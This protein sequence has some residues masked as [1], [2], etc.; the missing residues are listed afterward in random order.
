MQLESFNE[1]HIARPLYMPTSNYLL[2]RDEIYNMVL[3]RGRNIHYQLESPVICRQSIYTRAAALVQSGWSRLENELTQEELMSL[4]P[5]FNA[6]GLRSN[7]GDTAEII[8]QHD[9]DSQNA[10]HQTSLVCFYRL[11]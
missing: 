6:L 11:Y 3:N 7:P 1:S 8:W 4:R 9:E 10:Q 2:E 5:A